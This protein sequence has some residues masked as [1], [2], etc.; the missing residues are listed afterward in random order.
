MNTPMHTKPWLKLAA[1]AALLTAC[2]QP[3]EEKKNAT[4][5]PLKVGVILPL[6]GEL[7]SYGEPMKVGMEMA[8]AEL[9]SLA[10]A[11]QGRAFDLRF[12]DSQADAKSG[13]SAAQKLISVDGVRYILGDVSSSVTQALVPIAE[14]NKVF[15]LSPGASSPALEN[16]SPFFARN[17]PSS[18]SESAA[19]ATFAYEKLGSKQALI[20]YVNA[21]YG[22]GLEKKFREVFTGLGGS[23]TESIGYEFERTDFR[24]LIV[25]MRGVKA[26]VL[27]LAGNQREMG[28][29]MKQYKQAG[30]AIPVVSNISFLQPDCIALAGAAAEG[31][32][33]PVADYDPAN[34]EQASAHAFAQAYKRKTGQEVSLPFAVGYDAVMLLA[35]GIREQGDDPTKV[36]AY[37]RDLKDYPGALGVLQFTHGEV[38]MPIAIRTIRNGEVVPYN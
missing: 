30:L 7:A 8:K 16:I 1:F 18:V 3:A 25:K 32:M 28:N 4:E 24:N 19:A 37:I 20:V 10:K 34:P 11:G 29:F 21:E 27:Y 22:L 15:L 13:V 26:D 38:E 33:V 2:G 35:K 17:Y 31:V 12:N 36:A 14:Q 6:T 5:E 23:I 9:D